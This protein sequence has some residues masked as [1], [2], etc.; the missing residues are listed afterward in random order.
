VGVY[1]VV[2]RNLAQMDADED[3]EDPSG[4]FVLGSAIRKRSRQSDGESR[5]ERK[6]FT[7]RL[8]FT[9]AFYKEAGESKQK[10]F[11][12]VIVTGLENFDLLA[13][14][15]T[16]FL[17]QPKSPQKDLQSDY[18]ELMFCWRQILLY[19]SAKNFGLVGDPFD[20]MIEPS[21]ELGVFTLTSLLS[22]PLRIA[23]WLQRNRK[24]VTDIQIIGMPKLSFRND[25]TMNEYVKYMH[26]TLN[27]HGG[28]YENLQRSVL[29]F[30]TAGE[31]DDKGSM[32]FR[33]DA[34][35][36]W[37]LK[38]APIE[39]DSRR[40]F[41][42]FGIFPFPLVMRFKIYRLFSN[43]LSY[44]SFLS[45]IG[46]LP[47]AVEKKARDFLTCDALIDEEEGEDENEDDEE[48]EVPDEDDDHILTEKATA[49]PLLIIE[50]FYSKSA[51]LKDLQTQGMML[52]WFYAMQEKMQSER[53]QGKISPTAA[54]D[55]LHKHIEQCLG[56][57]IGVLAN[58]GYRSFHVEQMGDLVRRVHETLLRTVRME[59]YVNDMR[60]RKVPQRIR[61]DDFLSMLLEY[62]LAF[63]DINREWVSSATNLECILEVL[64]S[65]VHYLLGS[66]STTFANF[67]QCVMVMNARGHLNLQDGHNVIM[68]WRK[69]NTS[70]LGFVQERINQL[71]DI[72]CILYGIT[73]TE[74]RQKFI[75]NNRFTD[76]ALENQ[77]SAE[78]INGEIVGN[79]DKELNDQPQLIPE[80][81]AASYTALIKLG[82]RRDETDEIVSMSTVDLDKTNKRSVTYKVSAWWFCCA[83]RAIH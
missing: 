74:N 52:P 56:H 36:G 16:K 37:P 8:A 79:P 18:A 46:K 81:R 64:N 5:R 12:A 7:V 73:K 71:Q 76:V 44:D 78:S 40:T 21:G 50:R 22:V 31:K 6:P 57:H 43:I 11:G 4:R 23:E 24:D 17:Q 58:G 70:G 35:G 42:R 49:T 63:A 60:S 51:P 65:S 34:P 19:E 59:D 55:I 15:M 25:E 39:G 9:G 14:I 20:N 54:M 2:E 77:M 1:E 53:L 30:N 47:K 68:D 26:E 69:Q 38:S 48:F 82:I 41:F 66:H 3:A 32:E 45:N 72:F 67:F 28:T 29:A 83:L 62:M 13:Y 61:H 10:V 75:T 80:S 33:L 27:V